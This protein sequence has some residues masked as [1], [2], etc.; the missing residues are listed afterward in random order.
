MLWCAPRHVEK[1]EQL[2]SGATYEDQEE[3]ARG[4]VNLR[5]AG[6]FLIFRVQE[7]ASRSSSPAKD[8]SLLCAAAHILL[9]RV[10]GMA[11]RLAAAVE[12]GFSTPQAP[13]CQAKGFLAKRGKSCLKQET[14]RGLCFRGTAAAVICTGHLSLGGA[15]VLS[16]PHRHRAT[17]R[18][19][20]K[21]MGAPTTLA[22]ARDTPS[23][24][25]HGQ[26]DCL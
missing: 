23:A 17:M 6:I 7:P 26:K 2:F 9:P 4:Y 16:W 1:L 15:F 21:M 11:V 19:T 13:R 20:W 14:H 22:I 25:S 5:A 18:M 3:A 8:P 24:S 10:P 12:L